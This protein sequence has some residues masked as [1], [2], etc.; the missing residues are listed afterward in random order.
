M[1]PNT[2]LSPETVKE[3]L[4]EVFYTNYDQQEGRGIVT[5]ENPIFF[6]QRR[7]TKGAVQTEEF[8]PPGKWDTH[9]EEEEVH[10]ATVRTDN[11][12]THTVLNYKKALKIPVEYWEDE[13]HEGVENSIRMSGVR[14]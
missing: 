2:G 9:Q 5:A 11:K 6:N 4:D 3:S 1:G 12:K 13:M 7:T 10:V 8:L 14:A